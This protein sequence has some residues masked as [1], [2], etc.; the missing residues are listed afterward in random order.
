[1]CDKC[2]TRKRRCSGELPCPTCHAQ[3][4]AC[5]YTAP[6]TRGKPPNVAESPAAALSGSARCS[7]FDHASCTLR[8]SRGGSPDACDTP[9][10]QYLGPSSPFAFLRRAWKR[11]G[12]DETARNLE[13]EPSCNTPIFS[14]GDRE[15]PYPRGSHESN[16]SIE[17]L[18][19][20]NRALAE[21][22]A[23][24]F[25]EFGMPSYRFLHR[26]TFNNWL[27][28]GYSATET[29]TSYWTA[30]QKALVLL[31]LA[32]ASQYVGDK[33]SMGI[34]VGGETCLAGEGFFVTAQHLLR[35]ETGRVR[36]ESVQ[37]RLAASLYL[38]NTSRLNEAWYTLGTTVQLLV[39]LGLHRRSLESQTTDLVARECCRRTFWAAYTLDTYLSVML[40]RPTI[41]HDS[42]IDQQYPELVNDEDLHK[43]G[44][45]YSENPRDCLTAAAV[46][47]ARLAKIVRTSCKEL[48]S[49]RKVSEDQHLTAARQ[50]NAEI[51]AWRSQLPVFLSGAIHSSSLIP[52]LRRQSTVLRMA[53]AHAVMLVARPLILQGGNSSAEAQTLIDVCLAAAKDVFDMV[54]DVVSEHQVVPVPFWNTQ[55]VAFIALSTVYVWIMQRKHARLDGLTSQFD[56]I[57]L[58][59]LAETVQRHIADATAFH[60]PGLRYSIMLEE[61]QQ[62]TRR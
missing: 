2:K 15:L 17:S 11:L 28:V 1:A 38:L 31:V 10:G 34:A 60:S 42:D 51:V 33:H 32:T 44:I 6:Y 37:A 36:L 40:G 35:K 8:T 61:L 5:T 49:I 21:Q 55:Y 13:H 4:I 54:L 29:A 62:Q 12:Q 47:H 58:F 24:I 52:V 23:T 50:L 43:D 41:L 27:A 57:A 18:N 19:L 3:G 14:H 45:I 9:N 56:E 20:P 7:Q 53:C 46:H 26:E 22:L 25:F 30:A 39:A 48:Y 59:A 16:R